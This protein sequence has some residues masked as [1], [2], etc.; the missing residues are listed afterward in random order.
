M[1][2]ANGRAT[3]LFR[4]TAVAFVLFA[5]GHTFG[6]LSFKAPT[7]EAQ[8]VFQSMNSV[9]FEADGKIFSYGGWYRGFGLSATASMLFEAFFAWYLGGMAK[10]GAPEVKAL[11]WAFFLWQ[12]PGVALAWIYFGV[13]PMVLSVLVAALI[14]TATWL[15][16]AKAATE[17]R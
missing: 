16:T 15:A 4:I 12:L 9:H 1:K 7:Q 11:G 14:A 2:R 13:P 5:A 3:I 17:T 8:I 6:F 10:K